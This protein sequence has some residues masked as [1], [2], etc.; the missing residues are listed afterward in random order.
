DD[1]QLYNQ[2]TDNGLADVRLHD[3]QSGNGIYADGLY[4][5]YYGGAYK[6]AGGLKR[7]LW[8]IILAVV[9]CTAMA[10]V[11]VRIL[12]ETS[13]EEVVSVFEVGQVL[14]D[15]PA[16]LLR[17][18]GQ[19]VLRESEEVDDGDE[20]G[21]MFW[22]YDRLGADDFAT[23]FVVRDNRICAIDIMPGSSY[24]LFGVAAGGGAD[25]AAAVLSG[26]GFSC[27]E[28]D[29]GMVSDGVIEFYLP[30]EDGEALSLSVFVADGEVICVSAVSR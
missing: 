24:T 28:D 25:A 4:P 27:A 2:Y 5:G 23:C 14:G 7:N 10:L 30:I 8:I 16:E 12:R 21:D 3:A 13:E 1:W 22:R 6:K 11:L 18:A 29:A 19:P 17:I 20:A 15:S 26:C 9:V